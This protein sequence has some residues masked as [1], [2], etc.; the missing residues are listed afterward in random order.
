MILDGKISLLLVAFLSYSVGFIEF[1]FLITPETSIFD[2]IAL[3]CPSFSH[4]NQC[5]TE[6]SVVKNELTCTN[7]DG[8]DSHVVDSHEARRNE[9]GDD[10]QKLEEQKNYDQCMAMLPYGGGGGVGGTDEGAFVIMD[11]LNFM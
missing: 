11:L 1:N 6:R 2:E 10:Y 8:I 7:E 3:L 4:A 9:E 5:N